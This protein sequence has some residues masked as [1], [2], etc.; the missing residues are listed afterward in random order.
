MRVGLLTT[1][2]GRESLDQVIERVKKL[3]VTDLEI[4]TGNYP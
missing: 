1:L 3:G 2:F 4:G